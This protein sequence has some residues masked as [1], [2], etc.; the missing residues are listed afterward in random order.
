MRKL[1]SRWSWAL[2]GKD[3]L[4]FEALGLVGGRAGGLIGGPV[5]QNGMEV[6]GFTVA[7]LGGV[8]T[9]CK[10]PSGMGTDSTA[11]RIPNPSLD[12]S[13]CAHEPW[14]WLNELRSNQNRGLGVG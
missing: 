7:E 1:R 9:F 2:A 8:D 6:E 3:G 10:L 14:S 11:S 4:Y 13:N 5:A 12:N